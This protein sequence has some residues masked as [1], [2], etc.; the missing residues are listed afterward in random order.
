[1]EAYSLLEVNQYVKRVLALNFEEPFWVECEINQVSE[2]RSNLYLDLIEKDEHSD[3]ILAKN[4][5]TIW[6]RQLSFIRKKLGDLSDSII[7]DGV[8]VKLKVDLEYS[9]RYGL[10]LNVL[11]IDPSY[12]F[13]QFELNRQK[14]LAKLKEKGRIELN[15]QLEL[16]TVI[17]KVAVISSS[18]AAGFQDFK[19]QLNNNSYGYAF[20]AQLFPAAMQ[21]QKT[22]REVVAALREIQELDF[23]V[24]AIIR[25]G[26]S[27]LDLSSFDNYNIAHTISDMK[28]PVFTGIGHDID[29]TVTD[30]VANQ[31][32][33][34]PT[35]AADFII[36]HNLTF[37]SDVQYLLTYIQQRSKD[38]LHECKY[39]LTQIE[40][41]IKTIP[42]ITLNTIQMELD[43]LNLSAKEAAGHILKSRSDA[44]DNIEKIF[45]LLDPVKVLKRGYTLVLQ[46][47]QYK[48]GVKKLDKKSD[49]LEIEFH[50]G[51]LNAKIVKE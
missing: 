24:V 32:L 45:D 13:G 2:S 25:G 46:D 28:I 40:N 21:G 23:D 18:T 14:I 29:M 34:T 22:E 37:E 51:R 49:N 35:A 33:K 12:T 48:T 41:E 7:A 6:Y 20:N 1:M 16:P 43:Q 26:G 9:E 17:Q 39:N 19:N 50:D 27:K 4:S 8:K 30:L 44:I 31:I 11:D 36:E 3:N 10:S 42:R 5:G 38:I 15:G 47:G